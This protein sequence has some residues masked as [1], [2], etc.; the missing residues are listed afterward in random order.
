LSYSK[1][2][3]LGVT[4]ASEMP[5]SLK[6]ASSGVTGASELRLKGA[7]SYTVSSSNVASAGVTGD[8]KMEIEF[9]FFIGSRGL[10][11]LAEKRTL[12]LKEKTVAIMIVI[13]FIVSVVCV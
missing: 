4:G 1:S 6:S 9:V 2:A 12:T 5:S 3:S 7:T 13:A 8:N 10:P 11:G